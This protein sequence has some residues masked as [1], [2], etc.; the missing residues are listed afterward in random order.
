MLSSQKSSKKWT[1]LS[2]VFGGLGLHTCSRNTES[3]DSFFC[4][5]FLIDISCLFSCTIVVEQPVCRHLKVLLLSAKTHART[6]SDLQF[7][8]TLP[9]K[10]T[11]PFCLLSVF[12]WHTSFQNLIGESKDLCLNTQLSV[13]CFLYEGAP[14]S[15]FFLIKLEGLTVWKVVLKQ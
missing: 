14:D 10:Q 15:F 11:A 9:E 2:A 4:L 13:G 6:G 1:C 5:F 3:K 7:P 8:P 12:N